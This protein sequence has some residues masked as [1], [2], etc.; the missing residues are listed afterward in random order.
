M[1]HIG[2]LLEPKT[3]NDLQRRLARMMN[4]S[5]SLARE[6]ASAS[7]ATPPADAP[8]VSAE[9]V[10]LWRLHALLRTKWTPVEQQEQALELRTFAGNVNLI[11]AFTFALPGHVSPQNAVDVRGVKIQQKLFVH[12]VSRCTTMRLDL[13][14]VWILRSWSCATYCPHLP[15]MFVM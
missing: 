2:S 4:P 13:V 8:S 9:G 10:L 6:N 5:M 11:P 7:A 3:R 14:Y 15:G 12:F 1:A